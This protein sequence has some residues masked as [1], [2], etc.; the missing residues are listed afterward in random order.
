MVWIS[1]RSIRLLLEMVNQHF[2]EVFAELNNVG[3]AKS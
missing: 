3:K 1:K 2:Q